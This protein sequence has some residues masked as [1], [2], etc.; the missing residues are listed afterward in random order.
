MLRGNWSRG[1]PVLRSTHATDVVGNAAGTYYGQWMSGLR[2][3]YGVR[4]SAPFSVATPV[5]LDDATMWRAAGVARQRKLRHQNSLPA[6]DVPPSSPTYDVSGAASSNATLSAAD[7]RA[8]SGFALTG[9]GD[10]AGGGGGTTAAAAGR[11]ATRRAASAKD[12][13][14]ASSLGSLNLL[15]RKSDARTD[16]AASQ[17]ILAARQLSKLQVM[18]SSHRRVASRWAV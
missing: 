3:G 9:D 16:D 12:R 10:S 4:Q 1:I 11:S 14:L 7:L 6:I 18:P 17:V 15:R 8:R 2:H 13:S 5:R